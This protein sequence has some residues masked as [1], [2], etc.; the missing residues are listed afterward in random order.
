[1][2]QRLPRYRKVNKNSNKIVKKK[3]KKI[4]LKSTI[5]LR[6]KIIFKLMSI[7]AQKRFK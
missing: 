7:Q 6:L 4:K 5:A 1:M 2:H 3:Q